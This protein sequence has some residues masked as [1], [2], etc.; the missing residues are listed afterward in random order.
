MNKVLGNFSMSLKLIAAIGGLIVMSAGLGGFAIY[1]VSVVGQYFA[2][3]RQNARQS[4]GL[5]EA[6]ETLADTR[7]S[8]MKYRVSESEQA[9]NTVLSSVGVLSQRLATVKELNNDAGLKERLL[10]I[11]SGAK[12]YQSTF[13]EA[14]DWQGQRNEHVAVL[15][16]IG[17]ALRKNVSDIRTSAYKDGDITA[18]YYASVVQEHLMLGRLYAAKFLVDNDPM[19]AQRAR[20]EFA[21]SKEAADTLNLELQNPERRRLLALVDQGLIDYAATMSLVENAI[22]ERNKLL[23]DGLDTIGPKLFA[24]IS[25]LANE[26]IDNQNTI[27]PLAQAEVE[28]AEA[29]TLII[30][31]L[32]IIIGSLVGWAL[33]VHIKGGVEKMTKTMR[34]I[35]DGDLSVEVPFTTYKDELGAMAGALGVFKSNAEEIREN[36]AKEESRR[37]Q[38]EAD[39]RVAMEDLA[40]KFERDVGNIVNEVS[41]SAQKL[42]STSTELGQA[43][44]E[45]SGRSG[46]A[47]EAVQMA[48][49]NVQAV[50]A[51]TEE[52]AA[53]VD[54][55]SRNVTVAAEM[56]RSS[57][58]G[59]EQAGIELKELRRSISE[60]DAIIIS[61][62]EVAEQ[63]NLL[64]LNA[65]IEAARAG[66]AGKGF[67]V[68]AN[69][70][71]TLA[72]QTKAMTDG[73]STKV[74]AVKTAAFK[75]IEATETIISEVRKIDSTTTEMAASVEQQSSATSE[76]SRNA[77]EA[78]VG[79]SNA[80]ENVVNVQSATNQTEAAT[81][82]VSHAADLLSKHS[83]A[84]KRQVSTFL[85]EVRAA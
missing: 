17:P 9:A 70:V 45:T 15:D 54:E 68:V 83:D 75:A 53:G 14:W 30:A 32:I 49:A 22:L 62:N 52:L 77:Q 7:L 51:A 6:Q 71:K 73:I 2:D 47:G 1:E 21:I 28:K 76:I 44:Q 20:D 57:A 19:D 3:Y 13:S 64:A 5:A 85:A 74:D 81:G 16:S 33:A 69:E 67:T 12:D 59:A 34:S 8:V 41:D 4:I 27:G 78:A 61:I 55:V 10:A 37:Q 43:V 25:G 24:D 80:E 40:A 63:T 18:A 36:E 39:K 58:A 84:L 48:S 38:A 50:A 82:Q 31:A 60:V 65:T 23:V 35:A 11:E 56:A 66:E 79:T 42:R 46:S 26:A 72:A 29:R